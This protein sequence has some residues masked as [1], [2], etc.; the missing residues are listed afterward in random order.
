MNDR[1]EQTRTAQD[2]SEIA[3]LSLSLL[4]LIRNAAICVKDSEY[5]YF[6]VISDALGG[7]KAIPDAA[8]LSR[9]LAEMQTDS[10]ETLNLSSLQARVGR[11]RTD[12]PEESYAL[13]N[14]TQNYIYEN[15][16]GMHFLDGEIRETSAKRIVGSISGKLRD[17]KTLCGRL[18]LLLERVPE[19]I[20]L[21]DEYVAVAKKYGLDL[22]KSADEWKASLTLDE[23]GATERN[24]ISLSASLPSGSLGFEL[25]QIVMDL[26][27][28]AETAAEKKYEDFM[29]LIP[30][31]WFVD[32][33][34]DY[35]EY[36]DF[37]VERDDL[38]A[39][40]LARAE[41]GVFRTQIID[42]I[43]RRW[44]SNY[45]ARSIGRTT[46]QRMENLKF[47]TRHK[48]SGRVHFTLPRVPS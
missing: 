1:N 19:F 5:V 27:S 17:Q 22:V 7:S 31:A 3:R 39:W 23:V 20:E 13:Y 30:D 6:N 16:N 24:P 21:H 37:L 48:K 43:D 45:T 35:A 44:M 10:I 33:R 9:Q 46:I 11:R 26:R 14:L 42:E 38:Q 2:F 12:S 4:E 25:G 28:T 8:A 32:V 40:I 36:R 29:A 34:Q 18:D 15:P 41:D 47:I